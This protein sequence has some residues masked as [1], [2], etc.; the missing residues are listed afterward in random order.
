[1]KRA[2]GIL[3]L[4]IAALGL[5]LAAVEVLLRLGLGMS[6]D[7]A[8]QE[9]ADFAARLPASVFESSDDGTRRIVQMAYGARFELHP[10]LGYT[11]ARGEDG[12]NAAGFYAGGLEFPYTAAPDEFVVGIFGGS[13]AMQVAGAAGQIQ[14][15]LLP[16]VRAKGYEKVTVASFA[17]GAWRQ[18]Q[19][20][21][22]FIRY[23]P[24]IDLAI[25]VDGFNEI[26]QFNDYMVESWPT[27]FPTAE[28][29]APLSE[30][31]A[32]ASA[33]RGWSMFLNQ[34]MGYATAALDRSWFR[35]SLLAH[36]GWRVLA[37]Q[38]QRLVG[39][40]RDPAQED[41]RRPADPSALGSPEERVRAYYEYWADLM[42]HM[43][44]IGR[45][46]GKPVLHFIQPNQYDRGSKP[47]SPEELEKH[48]AA[49]N[50]DLVTREYARVEEMV[51]TLSADGVESH[52][53]GDLF[54][55]EQATVYSDSCCH[56]NEDGV[57][58]LTAAVM[59][60]VLASP[61]LD[62]IQKVGTDAGTSPGGTPRTTEPTPDSPG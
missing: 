46:Q 6:G 22:A 42:R 1:M 54:L 53:L 3:A 10:F 58:Q 44:L 37:S 47:L 36:L 28:V 43:Q 17:I 2:L 32:Y 16:I 61:S 21:H 13:V 15:A 49:N 12:A 8:A 7:D 30:H 55:E 14:E 24:T 31:T 56:F 4:G 48:V 60:E 50:F 26:I 39:G 11:F 18:P 51:G 38:H 5:S 25:V 59:D 57:R 19:T 40:E 35:S 52:F 45:E 34:Q 9:R 41:P 29:F 23:L 20:F 62:E 27:E 33:E